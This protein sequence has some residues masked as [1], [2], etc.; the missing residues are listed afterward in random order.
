MEK[1]KKSRKHKTESNL[2][3]PTLLNII[4]GNDNVI[5][6]KKTLIINN[7]LFWLLLKESW[8]LKISDRAKNYF[9][10]QILNWAQW[11]DI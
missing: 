3:Q 11:N 10:V 2:A 9:A 1:A 8:G 7:F 5:Q 6:N 4:F